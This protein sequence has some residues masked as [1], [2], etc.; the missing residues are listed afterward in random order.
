MEVDDDFAP[1]HTGTTATIRS[2]SL[3]GIANRYVSLK[4]GPNSADEIADG[5]RIGTD[6]TS[7]PVD[8][9][10]LFNTLDAKTRAGPAR[11]S[12]AGRATWYDGQGPAGQRQST[13]YFAPFLSSSTRLTSE[14]ALDEAIFKRF[15]SDTS[16]TVSAIAERRDDLAGLVS[17]TNTAFGGDRRRERVARPRARAAAEHAAQGQ[18]DLR[19]PALDARRPRQLLVDESKPATKD[20]APFLR[21][22][23]PLVA[24]PARRSPTCAR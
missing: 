16:T 19:E 22:L 7:A 6:N 2:T 23:R 24:K 3:S 14:L 8:L 5:G 15:V 12:S 11:T 20:L 13:K 4:P 9:D 21:E 1:L 10:V 18:H 17:N